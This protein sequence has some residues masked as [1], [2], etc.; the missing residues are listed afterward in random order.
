MRESVQSLSHLHWICIGTAAFRK[1]DKNPLPAISYQILHTSVIL[2][3]SG[4][5]EEKFL[6]FILVFKGLFCV[7]KSL[8]K[9][10]EFILRIGSF[11]RNSRKHVR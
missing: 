4:Y 7:I 9:S 3:G 5:D 2:N 1:P 10:S 11:L 6:I 8:F